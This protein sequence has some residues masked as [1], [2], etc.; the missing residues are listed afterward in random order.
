MTTLALG[1]SMIQKCE[2]ETGKRR[3]KKLSM[4]SLVPKAGKGGWPGGL[5]LVCPLKKYFMCSVSHDGY[6]AMSS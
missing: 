6:I 4:N 2:I 5:E 3:E 1:T